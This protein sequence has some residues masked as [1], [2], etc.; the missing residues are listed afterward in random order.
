M[1]K[2]LTT[3]V[4]I[5]LMATTAMAAQCGNDASGFTAWKQ[6]FAA[7]AAANGVGQLGL[8]ALANASY[9]TSTI[10]ADRNQ[11]VSYTHLTLPTIYSV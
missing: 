7:E 1:I 8:Q 3:A 10:S 2:T 5:T 9:S 11:P 4:G 6:A